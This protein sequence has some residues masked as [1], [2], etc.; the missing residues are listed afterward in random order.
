MLFKREELRNFGIFKRV[1]KRGKHVKLEI[2]LRDSFKIIESN[3]MLT[4]KM[5][6]TK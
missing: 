3:L 6:I 2:G 1:F 4:V 5:M